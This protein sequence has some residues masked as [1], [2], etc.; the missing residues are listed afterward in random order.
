MSDNDKA[1]KMME[2]LSTD[3]ARRQRRERMAGQVAF[4]ALMLASDRMSD[5][6][7]TPPIA[8][9]ALKAVEL[10]D[11]ILAELDKS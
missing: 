10:A 3:T 9:V 4:A 7:E 5:I 8:K 2:H 6:D 11:A 1:L